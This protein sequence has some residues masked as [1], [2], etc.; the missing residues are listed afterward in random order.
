MTE[1]LEDA[2]QHRAERPTFAQVAREEFWIVAKSYFA[3]VYGTLLV[4]RM[5]LRL[6]RRV[7]GKALGR[8]PAEA[9][10]LSP[11]E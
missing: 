1:L 3:P 8:K 7:D 5:L 6:T 4:L 9:P 2:E 11:A 10:W